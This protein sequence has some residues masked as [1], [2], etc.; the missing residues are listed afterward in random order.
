MEKPIYILGISA[1]YHDSA[2]CLLRNGEII[3]AAEEERFSRI[4]HDS[5]FPVQAL[6]FCLKKENISITDVRYVTFYEKPLVTFER[7]VE[8]Y[9]RNAPF[10]FNSFRSSLPVWIKNKIFIKSHILDQLK[11]MATD[12]SGELPELLFSPHHYSHASSAFYPSPFKNAA[13]ICIDG[14]GEYATTTIWRG[15]ESNLTLLKQ[16]NYPHSLGLL[17]SAFTYYCGFKVNDGE[18]KLMGLAPYGKP[19]YTDLIFN[20]LI[21]VS[22]DASFKLNLKYFNFETGLTMTNRHFNKLF[23]RPNRKSEEEIQKFHMDIAASIQDVLEKLILNLVKHTKEITGLDNLCLA[24]G[25]ALNCVSN[26]K[27]FAKGI[28]ND[29]WIQPASNDAGGSI[30]AAF[31]T[32]YNY[33]GQERILQV[34]DLMKGCQLGEEF[35]NFEIE[36]MLKANNANYTMYNSFEELISSTS[37]L[38]LENKVL[39][40]FQGRSEFGP[41][42]LGNRSIIGNAKSNELQKSL[43]QKIKSRE[44]FRP[45]APA[46]LQADVSVLFPNIKTSPYMLL[47]DKLKKEHQIKTIEK[48]TGFA[49]LNHIDSTYPAV[50]HVNNTSR[51]QTVTK[52]SN[53]RF[54]ELLSSIKRKI[55]LGILINTSFNINGEPIVNKPEEAYNCFMNTQMDALII[56]DFIIEKESQKLSTK[57]NENRVSGPVN[58]LNISV[59]WLK[60]SVFLLILFYITL[61]FFG[62]ER[63]ITPLIIIISFNLL[64]YTFKKTFILPSQLTYNCLKSIQELIN[65]LLLGII[66]YMILSP[67]ALI[68]RFFFFKKKIEPNPSWDKPET[69]KLNKKMF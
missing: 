38:I 24:G 12:N 68:L 32:H 56:G 21:E 63:S 18:Y 48:A 23:G 51:I 36:K 10:G 67:Y 43:N 27:L 52:E 61:P 33:Q 50:T 20:S 42:A 57:K 69:L 5:T 29:I 1:F 39:G 7:I 16:I 6:S 37:K 66:F 40:W 28:F 44:S 60:L 30:G 55:G 49:R 2:A 35:S 4:K 45:F 19:K 58:D 41:R 17:Y 34:N 26:G 59:F 15:D 25:V 22:D 53:H 11:E 8:T 54:F 31:G 64:V 46:I 47:V 9:L 62:Y 3:A 14:V 13:V 65:V